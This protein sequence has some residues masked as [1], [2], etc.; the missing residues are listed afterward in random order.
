MTPGLHPHVPQLGAWLT[1][2]FL[3]AWIDRTVRP[4]Q[5]GYVESVGA[6]GLPVE[7][8]ARTVMVTARLV[9]VFSLG[10]LLAP[11][12]ACLEAA[13]HGLDFLLGPCR[14]RDGRFLH[15][16]PAEGQGAAPPADLYDL[17]FILLALGAFS[18]TSGD[19]APLAIANEIAGRLEAHLA[20]PH[21]GYREDGLAAGE[22]RQFPHMHLLEACQILS[23]LGSEGGWE[24]RAEQMVDLLER[25]FL[26]GGSV[27][28][29]YERDWRPAPGAHGRE[30]QLGHQFEWA[31]LLYR[32]GALTGSARATRLADRL[33]SFGLA[34]AGAE[35]GP[36]TPMIDAID[37]DGK[38]RDDMRPLWP[39]TELLRASV[40]KVTFAGE[41]QARHMAD[42]TASAIF[43]HYLDPQTGLWVNELGEDNRAVLTSVPTRVLYHIVPALAAYASLRDGD[44]AAPN[45]LLR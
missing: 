34:C 8:G 2:R 29:W 41:S 37:R 21:G 5:P 3:P 16:V 11:D 19:A 13:R 28:E 44:F 17:A 42:S 45:P 25:R 27:G 33:Y 6:D 35:T 31:W 26:V 39:M 1:D 38:P 30:R 32:Q 15:L 43:T 10:H 4:G 23:R 20:D 9:Y 24:L 18:A 22:R 12:G 40:A 7:T 36:L 14:G